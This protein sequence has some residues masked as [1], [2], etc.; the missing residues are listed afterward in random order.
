MISPI[1]SVIF[2]SLM[3]YS[4]A[5]P[6]QTFTKSPLEGVWLRPCLQGALQVQI[7]EKDLNHTDEIFFEDNGCT[8][9]L[10]SFLNNGKFKIDNEKIDYQFQK[11]SLA[12]YSEKLVQ[13]FNSRK[14]CGKNDWKEN[15][16]TEI[17]G[18]RCA[19]FQETKLIQVPRSGEMRFGIWKQEVMK[20]FFGQLT[21]EQNGKTPESRP[22]SWDPRPYFKQR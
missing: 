7:F 11:V 22:G 4:H 15:S 6:P 17:T 18:L 2:S 21:Q 19:L 5:F 10:L 12:L 1:L 3:S 9:P 13:D 8:V 20:L 16:P 14:V